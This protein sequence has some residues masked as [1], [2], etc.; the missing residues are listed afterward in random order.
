MIKLSPLT[1][2][3]ILDLDGTLVVHN[4]YKSGEDVFLPGALEFLRS[5]PT[6]DTVIILT[7][8]ELG[9]KEKTTEFLDKHGVRYSQIIFEIPMGERVLV[10]DTKPSG[11][12][13][14]YAITPKRNE[15]MSSKVFEIDDNL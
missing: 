4:G 10:N 12:I 3:W 15:G 11:L 8:R 1:H 2:T 13:C 14:A 6:Q 7:A 9:A 5:I